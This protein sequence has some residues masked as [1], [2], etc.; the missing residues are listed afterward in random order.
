MTPDWRAL[1]D[2][3]QCGREHYQAW[4]CYCGQPNWPWREQCRWC[5]EH[6][7]H[8]N[9][10]WRVQYTAHGH[11]HGARSTAHGGAIA[12][13]AQVLETLGCCSILP[14]NHGNEARRTEEGE[15]V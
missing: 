8:E 11:G 13:P 12:A 7:E 15:G 1:Q 14:R 3:V 4:T 5:S 10:L 2:N 9:G 6:R